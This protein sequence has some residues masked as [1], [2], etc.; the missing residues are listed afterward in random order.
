ML[1]LEARR[2][3]REFGEQLVKSLCL[4]TGWK[5]DNGSLRLTVNDGGLA[6]SCEC[7][8]QLYVSLNGARVWL[9]LLTRRRVRKAYFYRMA[10]EASNNLR[11]ETGIR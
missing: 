9:P 2:A 4:S 7:C 3:A 1:C 10:I 11:S 8:L 6:V 5:A